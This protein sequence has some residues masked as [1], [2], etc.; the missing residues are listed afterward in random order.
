M[1]PHLP[2]EYRVAAMLN[3]TARHLLKKQQNEKARHD[4]AVSK[5][6]NKH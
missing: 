3:L 1:V 5:A 4:A 6:S 2:P